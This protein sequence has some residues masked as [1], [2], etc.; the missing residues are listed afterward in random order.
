[1]T[2]VDQRQAKNKA[3]ANV[4]VAMTI[5]TARARHLLVKHFT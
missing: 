2:V 3:S 5:D 4:E 1:M